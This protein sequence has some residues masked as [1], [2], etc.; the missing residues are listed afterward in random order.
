MK[1][2]K[3]AAEITRALSHPL[4]LAILEFIDTHPD[5]NVNSIYRF[6]RIEQSVASQ[7]LKILKQAN[8]VEADKEGKYVR[9][10][11]NYDRVDRTVKAVNN[12]LNI[13]A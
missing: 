1:H 10:R 5:T 13:K 7:H 4:R 9:Y 11:I 3:Q 12:F 2:V 6:L 8:I